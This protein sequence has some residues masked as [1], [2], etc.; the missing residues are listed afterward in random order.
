MKILSISFLLTLGILVNGISQASF[1]N[2]EGLPYLLPAFEP[3]K[4]YYDNGN[5]QDRD[6]NYYLITGELVVLINDR[7]VPLGLVTTLDSVIVGERKFVQHDM[8]FYELVYDGSVDL[9]VYHKEEA[10]RDAEEGAY[11]TKSQT[12][13][14]E[15]LWDPKQMQSQNY[16]LE[17]NDEFKRVDKTSF[18]LF[19][20]RTLSPAEKMS[21]FTRFFGKSKKEL[22]P[23]TTHQSVRFNDIESVKGLAEFCDREL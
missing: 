18:W 5:V 17:W 3:G 7:I 1:D 21:D 19:N 14:V 11:G 2:L 13:K 20:D 8:K 22:K 23:Y 15:Q 4:L 10:F 6:V 16:T 12:A 9:L